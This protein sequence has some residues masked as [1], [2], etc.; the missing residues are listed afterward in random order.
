MI[1]IGL[2]CTMDKC[3]CC[4]IGSNKVIFYVSLHY[5]YKNIFLSTFRNRCRQLI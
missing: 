5:E 4:A 2:S 3:D 1:N